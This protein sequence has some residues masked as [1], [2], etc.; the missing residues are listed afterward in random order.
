M[1]AKNLVVVTIPIYKEHL[2]EF[3]QKSLKQC[4][5]I[6]IQHPICF[7][8][9]NNLN[10]TQYKLIAL[11]YDILVTF[12]A[13]DVSYF[14]NIEGYNKLL[15]SS[16][17]YQNFISYHYI[18]IYQL[19]AWVFKDELKYWCQQG[20]DYIGAPWFEGWSN[21]NIESKFIGVGN[22]GFSLRRTKKFIKVLRKI[23]LLHC[24][25]ILLKKIHL[26]GGILNSNMKAINKLLFIL[27]RLDHNSI[28]LKSLIN[29]KPTNEDFI[30][31]EYIGK[32]FRSFLLPS[33]KEA[34][35]FSFETRP[36]YLF[37]KNNKK[38]PFGCHAWEKYE[39]KDFWKNH[40]HFV[41]I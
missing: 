40:I 10:L 15:L 26:K 25:N 33:F 21:T 31:G 41:E 24:Y 9:P 3:E 39:Y 12:K 37:K 30:W 29:L 22:G 11:K 27:I 2:T 19:D 35:K 6:L 36:S 5:K 34:M 8:H 13:F 20:Y 32:S 16:F 23:K 18:L 38:L 7:I 4:F 14:S 28:H 17:F 1:N